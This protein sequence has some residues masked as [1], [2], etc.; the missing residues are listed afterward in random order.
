MSKIIYFSIILILMNF[1]ILK[2]SNEEIDF[3]LLGI[4]KE[5]TEE[6]SEYLYDDDFR[7]FSCSCKIIHK[8]LEDS[9]RFVPLNDQQ[10]E[11]KIINTSIDDIKEVFL[12]LG[13]SKKASVIP[14]LNK[15]AEKF[16]DYDLTIEEKSLEEL[17]V[18][19][20]NFEN[21]I[22]VK[23]TL[24]HLAINESSHN[25][26]LQNIHAPQLQSFYD[27]LNSYTNNYNWAEEFVKS[28]GARLALLS[29]EGNEMYVE[30]LSEGSLMGVP[31][32]RD[33]EKAERYKEASKI[34][35]L[36]PRE[37]EEQNL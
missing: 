13:R 3:S 21:F 23:N 18:R 2:A 36:I 17:S 5:L 4:P 32:T 9:H 24:W 8:I 33:R 31:L 19:Q 16:Q 1:G 27:A 28:Y 30:A 22:K 35:K 12:V 34:L 11:Q 6:I 37:K 15:I 10:L 14:Q 7:N 25:D 20:N 26:D 29:E